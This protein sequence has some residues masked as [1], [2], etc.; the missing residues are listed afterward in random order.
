[1]FGQSL[2]GGPKGS[3]GADGIPGTADD[4]Y[5]LE[6]WGSIKLKDP[7]TGVQGLLAFAGKS[8][9]LGAVESRAGM[10]AVASNLNDWSRVAGVPALRRVESSLRRSRD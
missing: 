1:M 5:A 2:T 7:P 9:W 6:P 4:Q 8:L 3:P 10:L